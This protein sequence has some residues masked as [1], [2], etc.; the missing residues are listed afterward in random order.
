MSGI[1]DLF[2]EY[3]GLIT[4]PNLLKFGGKGVDKL[5]DTPPLYIC[6]EN[7]TTMYNPIQ[8]VEVTLKFQ[9]FNR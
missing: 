7:I 6:D 2:N 9:L 3:D 1:G 4:H 8:G 5:A